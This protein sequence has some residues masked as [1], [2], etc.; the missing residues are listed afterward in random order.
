VKRLSL[1]IAAAALG[2]GLLQSSHGFAVAQTAPQVT[3]TPVMPPAP[4]AT[5]QPNSATITLPVAKPKGTPTP[6]PPVD[7]DAKRV[8]ISGVWEVQIQQPTQT[9]YTHFKLTQNGTALTGQYL[10]TN[11]KKYPLTGTVDGKDVHLV[12][13]MPNGNALVFSGSVEAGTDM[14]GTLDSTKD[15]VGFTAEYRPKYK[16]IDNLSPNP[17][18]PG[19]QTGV[20]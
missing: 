2:I 13:T 16:W 12:V 17:G 14:A 19:G 3:P 5:G 18:I 15:T 20:P 1:Y 6:A 10:D 8:G 9:I 4:I 11:G 7:E